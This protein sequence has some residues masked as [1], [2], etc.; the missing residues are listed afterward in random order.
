MVL[1]VILGLIAIGLSSAW[2]YPQHATLG[3]FGSL[4]LAVLLGA[5]MATG[6][7]IIYILIEE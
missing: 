2:L 4:T 6:V 5:F 7:F 1:K 3:F